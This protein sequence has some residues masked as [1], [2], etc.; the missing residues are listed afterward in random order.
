MPGRDKIERQFAEGMD[1]AT[2]HHGYAATPSHD[3]DV[4]RVT[5]GEEKPSVPPQFLRPQPYHPGED[6]G[7]A[8]NEPSR[9]AVTTSGIH[10]YNPNIGPLPAAAAAIPATTL[11]VARMPLKGPGAN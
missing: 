5:F 3:T 11:D 10:S 4:M 8:V 1:V 6:P 2:R 7:V 9:L